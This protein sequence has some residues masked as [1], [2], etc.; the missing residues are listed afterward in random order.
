MLI[1]KNFLKR[2]E[3][4]RFNLYTIFAA[5]TEQKIENKKGKYYD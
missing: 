5:V 2:T 3:P 1:T 4:V